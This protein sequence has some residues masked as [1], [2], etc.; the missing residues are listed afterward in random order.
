MNADQGRRL[1]PDVS[2]WQQLSTAAMRAKQAGQ[3]AEA[4]RSLRLAVE[5]AERLGGFCL[6]D[7]L[8]ALGSVYVCQARFA[9]TKS[10]FCRARSAYEKVGG[11]EYPDVAQCLHNLADLAG[12]EGD[13]AQ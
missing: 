13:H 5:A 3:Y 4:E 6:P 1:P 2:R 8:N 10:L 9:E 7:S 12:K 11:K